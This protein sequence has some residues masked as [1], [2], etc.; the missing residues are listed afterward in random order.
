M[1][2]VN[3]IYLSED[4]SKP[5]N[6]IN[7]ALFGLMTQDWFRDW[8]LNE[9][10]LQSNAIVYP[11][12]NWY[13]ARPDLKVVAHDE[14]TLAWI[15]VELGTNEDQINDYRY[16]YS[17]PIKTV[18]GRQSNGGDLS[19]EEIACFLDIQQDLSKQTQVNVDYL[20]ELIRKGLEGH[21]TN[22]GRAAVSD[23][24]RSSPLVAGLDQRLGNRLLFDI[25]SGSPR[26][27]YLKADTT[28]TRSN[29][30]FSL[31]VRRRDSS[32]GTV[33]LMSIKA[34]TQLIFPSRQKLNRCLPDRQTEVEAYLRL[35]SHF[36][37][38]VD[39]LSDNANPPLRLNEV[40][41]AV[42]GKIDEIASCAKALAE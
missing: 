30:G 28:D 35:V 11:P 12:I 7:V 8:F 29:K 6:R 42:L 3:D 18:C 15:E 25:G 40:F 33:S 10:S 22:P 36:G 39:I 17:E 38:D 41:S 1:P 19:L 31:R 24:M 26:V 32:S 21:T 13:G 27:G 2:P 14:S 9:L 5:E 23:D 4:L 37:C 34:G 20:R 16:R